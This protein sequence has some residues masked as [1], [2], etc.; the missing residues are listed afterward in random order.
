[1]LENFTTREKLAE[2]EREIGW[3]ERVYFKKVNEG[4]M[5]IEVA[6]RQLALIKAIAR[7]YAHKEE[8]DESSAPD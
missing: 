6:A 2:L 8:P 3:R 5:K 4:T 1:M 7:D